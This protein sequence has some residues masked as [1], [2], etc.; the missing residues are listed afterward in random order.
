MR[1]R[2][3]LVAIIP[4][5]VI[6]VSTLTQVAT[7]GP[8]VAVT[9]ATGQTPVAMPPDRLIAYQSLTS[10]ITTT[11]A[12]PDLVFNLD[13]A[14]QANVAAAKGAA[15]TPVVPAP[16]P[17][18]AQ[19]ADTVTAA[20][21][22]GWERVAMCEEGGD[23]SADNGEFSGGLG[24]TRSNWDAYGGRAYAPEGSEASED[25]QILVAERIQA[26]PPDQYGCRGW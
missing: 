9:N 17:A 18:P 7:Q 15:S 5:A 24:I 26:T 2:I 20:E 10:T 8:A 14:L 23:W 4:I 25:D 3:A 11:G 6:T 12:G 13:A 22:A 19:P 1:T 21:R 16:V